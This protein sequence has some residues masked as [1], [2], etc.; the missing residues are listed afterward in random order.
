MKE[1]VRWEEGERG[2]GEFHVRAK[3]KKTKRGGK[4]STERRLFD[5]TAVLERKMWMGRLIATLVKETVSSIETEEMV[6]AETQEMGMALKWRIAT[7]CCPWST[8]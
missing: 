4:E 7:T 1:G 5:E 2:E 6:E 8:T 3:G